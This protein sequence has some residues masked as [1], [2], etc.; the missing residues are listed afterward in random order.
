MR[1]FLALR[2]YPAH[3][4]KDDRRCPNYPCCAVLCWSPDARLRP[5]V[6]FVGPTVMGHESACVGCLLRSVPR[7]ARVCG[8]LWPVGARV[9]NLRCCSIAGSK[10][11]NKKI[12]CPGTRDFAVVRSGDFF[13]W[14]ETSGWRKCRNN[15]SLCSTRRREGKGKKIYG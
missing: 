7:R 4:G 6:E 10:K 13:P 15:Y 9:F 3:F 2:L 14:K 11:I 5:S 1:M 8:G 12:T